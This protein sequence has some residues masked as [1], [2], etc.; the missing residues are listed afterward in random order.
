MYDTASELYNCLKGIYFDEYFELSD[1]KINKIKHK[2][3]SQKLFL[4]THNYN[5]WYDNEKS[6]YTTRKCDKE[7]WS[8]TTKTDEKSTDLPSIDPLKGD[9]KVKEG[10]K[11]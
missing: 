6:S 10:K 9:D 2:Y 5:V 11:R 4:E 1:A 8:D 7:E 3:D